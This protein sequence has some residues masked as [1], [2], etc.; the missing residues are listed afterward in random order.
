MAPIP[1]QGP[2]PPPAQ[3]P[4]TAP[5]VRDQQMPP[6]SV[7]AGGPAPGVSPA[8]DQPTGMNFAETEMAAIAEKLVNV[9]KVL[10]SDSPQ[11]MPILKKMVEA[12]SMLMNELQVAK[13]AAMGGSGQPPLDQ[14]AAPEGGEMTEG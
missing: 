5:P 2:A 14:G 12:G 4:P 13:D 9:A 1:G 8:L 11:L 6:M 3:G 10:E 7:F